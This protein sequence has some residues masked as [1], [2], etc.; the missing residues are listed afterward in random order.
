MDDRI[1]TPIFTAADIDKRQSQLV[2]RGRAHRM[3]QETMDP[4]RLE[5]ATGITILSATESIG[6][7]VRARVAS[8]SSDTEYGVLIKPPKGER[9]RSYGCDCR[10]NRDRGVVC[11]HIA[12]VS[13][14]YTDSRRKEW[15]FL[16][17]LKKMV[18]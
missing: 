17:D 9:I 7:H 10:D 13:V 12:A 1:K 2:A 4:R 14:W 16:R 18:S 11:K 15:A 8:A 3:L 5:R 6:G